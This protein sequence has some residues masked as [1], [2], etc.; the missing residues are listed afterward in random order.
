MSELPSPSNGYRA[1][2]DYDLSL[3]NLNEILGGM[4]SA[5]QP[6]RDVVGDAG[7]AIDALNARTL[8]V[9]GESITPELEAVRA[10][11]AAAQEE[12]DNLLGNDFE[13]RIASVEASLSEKATPDDAVALAIALGG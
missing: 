12:V 7:A 8:T 1:T 4:W 6:Y 5:L 9:I 11:F 10:Q 2:L 13:A 3:A